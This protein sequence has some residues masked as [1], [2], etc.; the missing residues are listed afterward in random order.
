MA[1]LQR[2]IGETETE[3]ELAAMAENFDLNSYIENRHQLLEE[4]LAA[5]IDNYGGD[6]SVSEAIRYSMFASSKRIRP[7][8]CFMTC[9]A[10]GGDT[11]L[12]LPAACALEMIHTYSLI[13]DDL[14]A[15]DN[16]DMRRGQPSCHIKF[17]EAT[18]ILTGDALLSM[19]YEILGNMYATCD[20]LDEAKRWLRVISILGRGAGPNGI[21]GGQIMDLQS[22][23]KTLTQ[24]E[25]EELS[26]RKTALMLVVSLEIGAA[27]SYAS[28]QDIKKMY[29]FGFYLGLAFQV[30]DD[31]LDMDED[32]E[33]A[34]SQLS[35]DCPEVKNTFALLLGREGAQ[36][37]AREYT[38]KALNVLEDMGPKFDTLRAF[39]RFLA[40]RRA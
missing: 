33:F 13:H 24:E 10:F 15:M 28:M 26:F 2:I 38:E 4:A 29:E 3:N 20:A 6:N 31:I 7:I 11:R 23:H 34:E 36:E 1:D 18:A 21:V 17:D 39:T 5:Y 37:L 8:L 12:A 22:L 40:E 30:V 32:R 25:L 14:P 27:L 19:A 35:E 9:E 16:D